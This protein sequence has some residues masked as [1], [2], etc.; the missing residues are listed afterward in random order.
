VALIALFSLALAKYLKM[1]DAAPASP[2]FDL[3]LERNEEAEAIRRQVRRDAD[4]PARDVEMSRER[5]KLLARE[6]ER[7]FARE[8][9][10]LVKAA[11]SARVPNPSPARPPARSA[12]RSTPAPRR[13]GARTRGIPDRLRRRRELPRRGRPVEGRDDVVDRLR[14][15]AELLQTDDRR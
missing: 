5:L 3:A 13:R 6:D 8:V 14:R 15:L 4:R 11:S 12:R 7:L 2:V 1:A 9:S 10:R